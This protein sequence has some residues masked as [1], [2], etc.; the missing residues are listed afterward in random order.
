VTGG[1]VCVTVAVT[2]C[3]VCSTVFVTGDAAAPIV[4]ADEVAALDAC[5]VTLEVVEAR[6]PVAVWVV[7]PPSR[8]P[9]PPSASAPP[10][11]ASVQSRNTEPAMAVAARR[12]R[13]RTPVAY[14]H[15]VG[16][17]TSFAPAPGSRA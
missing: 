2:G 13:N 16:I 7:D 11:A 9:S 8:P 5:C 6:A 3:V 10:G 12:R 17:E 1:V 14:P 4:P 15:R